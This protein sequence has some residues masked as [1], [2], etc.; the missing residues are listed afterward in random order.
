MKT[1]YINDHNSRLQCSVML[2][3]TPSIVTKF[4]YGLNSMLFLASSILPPHAMKLHKVC[5]QY[6]SEPAV[7]ALVDVDLTLARGDWLSITGP[8]G[9]AGG[10]PATG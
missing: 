3:F 1:L 5:R 10:P 9:P 4:R 8:S 6:S 7:H 2:A